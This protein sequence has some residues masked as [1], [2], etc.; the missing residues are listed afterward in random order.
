MDFKNKPD[1]YIQEL[2]KMIVS[3]KK[4]LIQYIIALIVSSAVSLQF[5]KALVKHS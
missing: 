4:L 1:D 3:D 5:P 2:G